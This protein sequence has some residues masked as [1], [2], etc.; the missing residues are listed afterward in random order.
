MGRVDGYASARSTL[1]HVTQGREL[2]EGGF[3]SV[4]RVFVLDPAET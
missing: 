4:E 1:L 3:R 2:S